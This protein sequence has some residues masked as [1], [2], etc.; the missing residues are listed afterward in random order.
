MIEVRAGVGIINGIG[1]SVSGP[2][3]NVSSALR[4]AAVIKLSL[5]LTS[6][7]AETQDLYLM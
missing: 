3:W 1:F 4:R 2:C 7:A 5:E 6:R